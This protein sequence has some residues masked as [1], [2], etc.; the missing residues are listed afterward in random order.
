MSY[1]KICIS[2]GHGLLVRGASGVIDEVDEAR[3]VVERL[4]SELERIGITAET[5]HDDISESQSENLERIVHWH[6]ERSRD[7]D[8]SVHFNAYV[9]TEKSM[10]CEVLYYSQNVLAGELSAAIAS[11][12]FINRGAKQR[13]DLYF[14]SNCNR[15]AVLLEIC[16]VDS[17]SDCDV[18][19]QEFDQICLAIAQEL[20]LESVGGEDAGAPEVSIG[21]ISKFGGPNDMGVDADEGLAFLYDVDDAP[22]LF[23]PKQPEGTSGLARRL[24]PFVPY[25]AMRWDYDKYPKDMLASM[26]YVALVR[27]VATGR[28]LFAFPSDWGPHVDT[29]RV[30]DCSPGLLEY[31]DL[32]TDDTVE[33]TWPLRRR[34]VDD[35]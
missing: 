10:G 19:A 31:L 22:F 4:A 7:L 24:N 11:C 8:I 6:N 25:I 14:L 21:K 26:D 34:E 23:L 16:F 3:K 33:V 30:C 2:S 28:A 12:G 17:V 32:D 29:D 18:Y 20:E 9:E 13:T 5:F 1:G 35:A 27:S 15:P